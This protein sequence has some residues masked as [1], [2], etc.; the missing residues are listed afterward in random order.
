MMMTFWYY[1]PDDI[2]SQN[3]TTE[4]VG[5]SCIPMHGMQRYIETLQ[6]LTGSFMNAVTVDHYN[7]LIICIDMTSEYFNCV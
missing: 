4:C 5:V 2:Q 3:P 6:F 1:R 7:D